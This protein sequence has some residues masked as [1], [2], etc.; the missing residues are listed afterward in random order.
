MALIRYDVSRNH[1]VHSHYGSFS[2]HV[3]LP[4]HIRH[5]SDCSFQGGGVQ[6]HGQREI[7]KGIT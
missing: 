6:G 1:E 2:V 3:V 4:G 5:V 7:Q